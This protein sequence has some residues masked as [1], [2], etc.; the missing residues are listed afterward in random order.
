MS[1]C[2]WFESVGVDVVQFSSSLLL[3]QSLSPSI[4]FYKRIFYFNKMYLLNTEIIMLSTLD[5]MNTYHISMLNKCSDHHRNQ[6]SM[7]RR[8][9]FDRYL[10]HYHHYSP[11]VPN[12]FIKVTFKC[13]WA[14]K[15]IKLKALT[16][17]LSQ[18][19][20]DGMH[21]CE[22]LHVNSSALQ[23][24]DASFWQFNSSLPSWQSSSPSG[25]YVCD[26]N[27]IQINK[28]RKS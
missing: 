16:C 28:Y 12:K 23:V 2:L 24:T 3:L 22:D 20:D 27:K 13:L 26:R 8:P 11:T 7:V 5:K 18:T 21:W 19:H 10:R 4:S 25:K 14:I 6:T 17:S 1:S 15:M 9:Y